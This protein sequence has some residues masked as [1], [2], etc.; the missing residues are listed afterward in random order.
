[1]P[2]KPDAGHLSRPINRIPVPLTLNQNHQ[3]WDTGSDIQALQQW[4]NANGFPLA[5][6]GAGS[7]GNETTTFGTH[8]YQA[9]IDFQKSKG[10]PATG[11]LGPLT[12]GKLA[13]N[14]S[15]ATSPA[16]ETPLR[17]KIRR[18]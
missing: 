12:R 6:S 10:L 11:F 17:L 16:P 9:L 14:F 18:V 13:Q 2:S 1:V 15:S 5:Q 8:T 3:L 4:L 7:P